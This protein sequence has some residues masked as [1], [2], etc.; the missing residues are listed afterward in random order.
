MIVQSVKQ[1]FLDLKVIAAMGS[2]Y[3]FNTVLFT[4]TKVYLIL[5]NHH[6][7]RSVH[8]IAKNALQKAGAQFVR[9]TLTSKVIVLIL[10][11]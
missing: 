5:H 10:C 1:G 11:A 8:L 2:S 4:T 7:A 6:H 9:M 3:A